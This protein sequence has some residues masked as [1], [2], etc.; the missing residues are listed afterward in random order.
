MQAAEFV[1]PCID[2]NQIYGA[3]IAATGVR[4]YYTTPWQSPATISFL[5]YRSDRFAPAEVAALRRA[6]ARNILAS[7]QRLQQ[8]NAVC[9]LEL[10]TV[11]GQELRELPTDVLAELQ[12]ASRA[13]LKDMADANTDFASVLESLQRIGGR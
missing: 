9:R 10:Q 4:Y 11:Y 13:V 6:Q 5:F 2:G 3:G 12:S 7:R 8:A 1:N